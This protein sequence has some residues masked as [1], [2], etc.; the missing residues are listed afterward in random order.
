MHTTSQTGHIIAFCP[1]PLLPSPPILTSLT[2]IMLKIAS[3]S[4]LCGHFVLLTGSFMSTSVIGHLIVM[5]SEAT[6]KSSSSAG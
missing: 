4:K 5:R 1:V 3:L 2:L 6:S